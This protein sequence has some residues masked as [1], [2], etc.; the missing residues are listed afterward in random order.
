MLECLLY[1]RPYTCALCTLALL[2]QSRPISERPG[3]TGLEI[4]PSALGAVIAHH[5]WISPVPVHT[6]MSLGAHVTG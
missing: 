4:G 3:R 6:V 1:E 5:T 2:A